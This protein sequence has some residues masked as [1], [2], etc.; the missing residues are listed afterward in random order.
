MVDRDG[1]AKGLVMQAATSGAG[2]VR[3]R[4]PG[5]ENRK[6]VLSKGRSESEK[7]MPSGQNPLRLLHTPQPLGSHWQSRNPNG[8]GTELFT[9]ESS[10]TATP[11]PATSCIVLGWLP[12]LSPYCLLH[13]LAQ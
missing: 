10:Q 12:G 11:D 13:G 3:E 6:R 7:G 8:T 4:D 1:G 5:A 2:G 9:V